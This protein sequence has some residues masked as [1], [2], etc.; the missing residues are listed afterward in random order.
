MKKFLFTL[1]LLMIVAFPS[2]AQ[3][4]HDFA[5][6]FMETYGNTEELTCTTVSPQMMERIIRLKEV[7][8]GDKNLQVL[9]QIKSIRIIS[10][11][12]YSE[13][14]VFYKKAGMLAREN[15][16]RYKRYAE[17]DD[18]AIYIRR[19]GRLIV[20]LVVIRLKDEKNFSLLNFTGNMSDKFISQVMNI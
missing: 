8:G 2:S 20:E 4:E 9:T 12:Q 15:K 10:C 7:E 6:H 19:R 5:A 3:Q 11:G 16:K 13:A 17:K 1:I 18:T 14:G